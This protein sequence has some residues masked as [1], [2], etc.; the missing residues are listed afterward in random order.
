MRCKQQQTFCI[1]VVYVIVGL[2]ILGQGE[3]HTKGRKVTPSPSVPVPVPVN[4]SDSEFIERQFMKWVDWVGT[5]R[6]SV[7][8]VAQNKLLPTLYITVDKTPGVGDFNCVKQALDS[9]PL[10]NL[11]R[12]VI[13]VNPGVYTYVSTYLYFS[14]ISLNIYIYLSSLRNCT[15]DSASFPRLYI[16]RTQY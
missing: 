4:D 12:V 6:H 14:L 15:R 3:A 16:Q 9:L 1:L 8:K 11:V 13:K 2:Q 5:L 10:V 7:F